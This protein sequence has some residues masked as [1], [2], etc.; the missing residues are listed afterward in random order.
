MLLFPTRLPTHQPA[1]RNSIWLKSKSLIYGSLICL[2]TDRFSP[3]S[4]LFATVSQRE[5]KNAQ[6]YNG[7]TIKIKFLPQSQVDYDSSHNK[8]GPFAVIE[9]SSYYEAYQHVL[10]GLQQF[11]P[12]NPL[13]FQ[14]YIVRF[15][16]VFTL[17]SVILLNLDLMRI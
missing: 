12:F 4:T 9:S 15:D 16:F 2:S 1:F 6:Q 5:D 14:K 17:I 8:R 10:R 11:T 7:K 13:P 3:E